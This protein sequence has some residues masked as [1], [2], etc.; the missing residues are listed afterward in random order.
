MHLC[1]VSLD[2]GHGPGLAAAAAFASQAVCAGSFVA[3]MW[4]NFGVG[5]LRVMAPYSVL[6][7][8]ETRMWHMYI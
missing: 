6:Y 4:K 3:R 2:A 1:S 5:T 8:E 7:L